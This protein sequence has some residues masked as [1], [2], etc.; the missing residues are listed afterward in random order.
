MRVGHGCAALLGC[1]SVEAVG[2]SVR[3]LPPTPTE[4]EH[5]YLNLLQQPD[6][7]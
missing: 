2:D 6:L 5:I 4:G 7:D 1:A 3:L